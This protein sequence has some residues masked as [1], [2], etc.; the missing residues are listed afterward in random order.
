MNGG[1]AVGRIVLTLATMALAVAAVC[2]SLLAHGSA[3]AMFVRVSVGV[4]LVSMA[5]IAWLRRGERGH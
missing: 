1:S 4:V 5:S 3:A 2:V